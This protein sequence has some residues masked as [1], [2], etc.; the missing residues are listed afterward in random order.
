VGGG[1]LPD[2]IADRFLELAGGQGARLVIIP[3]ASIR[4]DTPQLLNSPAYWQARGAESVVVLHTRNRD[5]SND[6]AFVRPLTAATGVWMS[7]GSQS[8]LAAAY[9]GTLVERELRRLLGRGGV[10]GGTSAGAAVMSRVMIQGG[11]PHAAVGTGFGLLPGV[12][13]D[14]HFRNRHRLERLL[15]VVAGHTAY[16]GLGID[17]QTG[18]V[19]AGGAVTVLGNGNVCLCPADR[20]RGPAPVRQLKAGDQADLAD[21]AR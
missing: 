18:V 12:V 6:P 7:G 15:E 9:G 4:A 20:G 1:P 11:N 16:A 2:T 21:L 10:I 5:Q 19:V 8:R 17:E 14:T 13:I 3:T